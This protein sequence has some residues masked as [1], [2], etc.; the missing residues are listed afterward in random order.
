MTSFAHS[1]NLIKEQ[2][3]RLLTEIMKCDY[4]ESYCLGDACNSYSV[5]YKKADSLFALSTV[6]DALTY[7]S[8]T[9]Y[10]LKY[11]SF[12]YLLDLND[13]IAFELLKHNISDTR[14]IDYT[15]ADMSSNTKIIYLL[16]DEYRDFI[17]AKYFFGGRAVVRGHRFLSFPP[18]NRS[19]YKKRSRELDHLLKTNNI[20]F[21]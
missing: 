6:D 18:A 15:F 1:Q 11:Y 19:T 17:K 12:L 14:T 5:L 21:K 2:K 9:S 13:T 8:D 20:V 3:Q 10:S 16:V 7:F 4:I